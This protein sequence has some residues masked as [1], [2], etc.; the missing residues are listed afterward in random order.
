M[1]D[2]NQAQALADALRA[3]AEAEATYRKNHDLHGDGSRET[4][5]AWDM[6][7]R[8]G[9]EAREALATYD[10]G[11]QKMDPVTVDRP[12]LQIG[13]RVEIVR[14]PDWTYDWPEEE[15]H[16]V[17]GIVRDDRQTSGFN[18]WLKCQGDEAYTDD[19]DLACLR[20]TSRALGKDQA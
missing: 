9:D 1:A 10:A 8:A 18:V 5:R 12:E 11:S 4:G 3:L 6:M 13:D 2:T 16:E 20:K 7:R 19:F 15:I 14:G 17:V